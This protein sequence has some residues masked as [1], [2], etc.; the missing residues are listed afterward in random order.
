MCANY[1][2]GH[3]EVFREWVETYHP[4]TLL[5]CVDRSSGSRQ[6]LSV[7]GAGAVYINRPYWIELLEKRLRTPVD[8]I[9][10]ENIFIIISS[11]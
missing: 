4:I 5:L 8:N 11:L 10:Q 1:P 2:K 9:L 6:D 3:R 7:K